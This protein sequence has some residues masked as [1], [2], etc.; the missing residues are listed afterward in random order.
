MG[1]KHEKSR[2]LQVWNIFTCFNGDVN[3]AVNRKFH[4][5][6]VLGRNG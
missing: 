6:P 5:Q 4:E 2:F 3:A 1:G